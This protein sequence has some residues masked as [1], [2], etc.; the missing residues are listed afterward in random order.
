MCY[1]ARL[2]VRHLCAIFVSIIAAALLANCGSD[3]GNAS[4]SGLVAPPTRTPAPV[5]AATPEATDQDVATPLPPVITVTETQ[6]GLGTASFI[7]WSADGTQLFVDGSRGTW[8][9]TDLSAPNLPEPVAVPWTGGP[10]VSADGRYA[11]AHNAEDVRLLWDVASGTVLF[12]LDTEDAYAWRVVFSAD[13]TQAAAILSP[14]VEIDA[15]TY[16]Y[17]SAIPDDS[18]LRLW[19][20]PS[21]AFTDH[22]L[23]D[24]RLLGM[25]FDPHGHLIVV[26]SDNNIPRWVWSGEAD[27][28]P[29][30]IPAESS[31]VTVRVWDI[32]TG[33]QI[34]AIDDH[35]GAVETVTL[36]QDTTRL[37]G[38]VNVRTTFGF[39]DWQIL[40]WDT[41]TG[42]QLLNE[43]LDPISAINVRAFSPD[44]AIMSAVIGVRTQD[45]DI[46]RYSSNTLDQV[47][48]WNLDS[49]TE[50]PPLTS[51]LLLTEWGSALSTITYSPDGTHLAGLTRGGLIVVWNVAEPD[52]PVA[53]FSHF[54]GRVESVAVSPDGQIVYS[55]GADGT[56]RAWALESGTDSAPLVG[57]SVYT[58]MG[59]ETLSSNLLLSKEGDHAERARMWN[60]TTGEIIARFEARRG[61]PYTA[62]SPGGIIMA[63]TTGGGTVNLWDV[64]EARID[65]VILAS[66]QVASLAFTPN[67]TQLA[68][69]GMDGSIAL[70]D[71][72]SGD[73][74]TTL[75]GHTGGVTHLVYTPGG[76]LISASPNPITLPD[77]RGEVTLGAEPDLTVRQWD[78]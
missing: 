20:I 75:H 38:V 9:Y 49:G 7:R 6:L 10:T 52:T 61:L 46:D 37:V 60:V 41:A 48:R 18:L 44:S 76:T 42:A 16:Y 67:D 25:A 59:L 4:T 26:G 40:A 43:Q 12:P 13:S 29:R 77:N 8:V 56:L 21:G 2:R 24:D 34:S 19:D 74:I 5:T 15:P 78:V 63:S 39:T 69:G 73:A 22:E 57:H 11:S 71:M 62:L 30:L 32:T 58:I 33:A 3:D 65:S 31:D 28:E 14:Q 54:M 53:E 1:Y 70:W 51:N 17:P 68:T 45:E 72:K 55:G 27:L 64:N 50:E 47:W 66:Q 35:E 36:S 23:P